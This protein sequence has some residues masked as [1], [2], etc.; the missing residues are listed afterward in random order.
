MLVWASATKRVEGVGG[1]QFQ[2]PYALPNLDAGLQLR[3]ISVEQ[4]RGELLRLV[5][6]FDCGHR[7]K[8][9]HRFK[10]EIQFPLR[11]WL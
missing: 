7:R 5:Q 2:Q 3:E 10:C 4:Q 11:S 9:R 1:G 8:I 6:H